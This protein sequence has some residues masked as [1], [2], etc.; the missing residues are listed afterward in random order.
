MLSLCLAQGW[1]SV[2]GSKLKVITDAASMLGS[3]EAPAKMGRS[4]SLARMEIDGAQGGDPVQ[5]RAR[6]A[7]GE[8]TSPW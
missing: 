3:S 4:F 1:R 7:N 8:N 6:W 2:R 5:L